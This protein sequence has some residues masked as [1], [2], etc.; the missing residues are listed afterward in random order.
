MNA[1]LH[2]CFLL[3]Q[4][5][6]RETSVI[7]DLLTQTEGRVS[8]VCKGVRSSGNKAAGLRSV[9]QPF[10]RL[11]ISWSGKSALK[12]LRSAEVLRSSPQFSQHQLYAALYLNELLMRLF[13]HGEL[14][15]DLF[16]EYQ[17]AIEQL[18]RVEAGNQL[19][20]EQAL[21][22]FEFGL[23]A[24]LGFEV[25]FHHDNLSGEAIASNKQYVYQAE[26]GFTCVA[27]DVGNNSEANDYAEGQGSDLDRPRQR[28]MIDT[29]AGAHIIA[30]Q[31]QDYRDAAVR[32]LAKKIIRIALAPHL[33]DRPLKSREFY[34]R[35]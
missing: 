8:L 4:R 9:L 2:H 16:D 32:K 33:G 24:T 28:H 5:P 20:T 6:Y 11:A 17:H 19:A 26:T 14:Q 15:M 21:R 13:Q 27:E 12:S 3:H 18:T 31:Q 10:A 25:D 1:P 23:L 22:R 34:A 29:V 7:V 35:S 30:L